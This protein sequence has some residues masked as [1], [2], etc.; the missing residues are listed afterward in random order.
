[1]KELTA[2]LEIKSTRELHETS[3]LLTSWFP[4]ELEDLGDDDIALVW[5]WFST[6]TGHRFQPQCSPIAMSSSP[7]SSSSARYHEVNKKEVSSRLQLEHHED[8]DIAL[9]WWW[10]S[11]ETGHRFHPQCGPSAM[12]SSPRYSRTNRVKF[13]GK[14]FLP[15]EEVM[16]EALWKI[17]WLVS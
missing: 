12:S 7:R 17:A 13:Y 15:P 4:Q 8:D 1:M 5:W 3:F 6:E 9:V 14:P 16:E 10:F 2:D 11:T